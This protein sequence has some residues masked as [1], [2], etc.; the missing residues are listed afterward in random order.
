MSQALN[1]TN[2]DDF[3]CDQAKADGACSWCLSDPIY[4]QYHH[5]VWGR[6]E[7]DPKKLFAALCLEGQQAGLSWITV[8]KKK[9]TY[10][11]VFCGFDPERIALFTSEDIDQLMT[12]AGLIRHRKKLEAIVTN[13][14]AYL[15]M[16]ARGEPFSDWVWSFVSGKPLVNRW[17]QMA[18][19]PSQTE[20]SQRLSKALKQR[21]FAFVGPTTA[22]AFM[23]ACGLV[24]DH[25]V[26]CPLWQQCQQ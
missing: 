2:G 15:A 7:K 12:N 1:A 13:A 10:E 24:N 5:C 22:Y 11:E 21:G 8:L 4:V 16:E 9:A 19:V 6:P 20:T 17:G 26:S 14:K 3:S 23:Q 25:L 18:D